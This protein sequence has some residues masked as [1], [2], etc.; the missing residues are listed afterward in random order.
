MA[1]ENIRDHSYS[2]KSDVWSFAVLLV[3]IYS[4]KTP[5]PSMPGITYHN[6][7]TSLA[8]SVATKVAVGELLPEIPTNAPTHIAQL[9]TECT[10]YQADD[11]PSFETVIKRLEANLHS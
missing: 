5:Y 6:L 3:E 11:R 10:Q 1:P 2:L 4:R 9:I 7:N 8:L